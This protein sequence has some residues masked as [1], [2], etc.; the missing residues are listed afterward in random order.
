MAILRNAHGDVTEAGA[1][2]GRAESICPGLDTK[3]RDRPLRRAAG[4]FRGVASSVVLASMFIPSCPGCTSLDRRPQLGEKPPTRG[5]L[6]ERGEGELLVRC[7]EFVSVTNVRCLD[8]SECDLRAN[9]V[10]TGGGRSTGAPA[11]IAPGASGVR[12]ARAG[13]GIASCEDRSRCT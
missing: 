8:R 7:G 12:V 3:R 1:F 5:V 6:G 9:L 13:N 10:S 4:S 2:A 11:M